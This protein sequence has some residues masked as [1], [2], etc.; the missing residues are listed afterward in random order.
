MFFDNRKHFKLIEEIS[1]YR[2]NASMCFSVSH[3][4][5]RVRATSFSIVLFVSLLLSHLIDPFSSSPATTTSS[6]T[7]MLTNTNKHT[8]EIFWPGNLRFFL[9]FFFF[10]FR[11]TV[12]YNATR[13]ES[14][15]RSNWFASSLLV[16][17]GVKYEH[18]ENKIKLKTKI[19]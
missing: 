2:C 3:T 5:S 19:E 18:D 15:E 12:H 11:L 17:S 7:R 4:K 16:T 10:V 1:L 13:L 6:S 14:T 9:N 8:G